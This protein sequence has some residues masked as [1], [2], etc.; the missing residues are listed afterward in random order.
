[1]KK[2]KVLLAIAVLFAAVLV[3]NTH[4][5]CA[6][7]EF[8][9]PNRPLLIEEEEDEEVEEVVVEP[10]QEETVV[11]EQTNE[12]QNPVEEEQVTT[13]VLSERPAIPEYYEE[14]KNEEVVE[15]PA[16]EEVVEEMKEYRA[17]ATQEVKEATA[18]ATDVGDT[19]EEK[20]VHTGDMDLA[21]VL[22]IAI[23]SVSGAYLAV[24]QKAV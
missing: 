22:M 12:V 2:G 13:I 11:E 8:M 16:Q 17:E 18:E 14:D 4:A 5:V 15:E 23:C 1:M 7:T 9:Q 10:T 19:K 21:Q 3:F 20:P 24:K 6:V